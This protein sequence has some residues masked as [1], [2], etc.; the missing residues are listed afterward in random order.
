MPDNKFTIA[1]TGDAIITRR[2]VQNES[3]SE[4]FDDLLDVFSKADVTVTQLETLLHNFEVGPAD[5]Y[6]VH[7]RTPPNVVED[8]TE[9]GCTMFSTATNHVFDYGRHGIQSTI[10]ELDSRN[11]TFAGTGNNLYE[12]RSPA[13][14]ESPAGRVGLVS[15]CSTFPPEADAGPQTEALPGRPGLNPLHVEKVYNL[16]KEYFDN[17]SK[18][19]EIIGLEEIKEEE[20][21]RDLYSEQIEGLNEEFEFG[22][23]MFNIVDDKSK[24]GIDYIVDESDRRN[25][26]EWISEANNNADLVVMAIHAHQGADGYRNTERTPKFLID[27][28]H[29]CIDAGADVIVGTGPHKLRG[30][31]IYD[32][33]PIF[34]S[35]GN[36]ISHLETI[37][38]YSPKLYDD[39]GVRD[40]TKTSKIFDKW[41]YD[42]EGNP[43][44]FLSEESWW[45]SVIP[46]CYFTGETEVEQIKLHPIILQQ[47]QPRSQRGTPMYAPENEADEILE[48]IK[49]LSSSFGT[50]I[51]QDG[52][53]GVINLN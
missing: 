24:A 19:S 29:D 51:E 46:V 5:T 22:E 45:R 48:K 36:F 41:F 37:T 1:A 27:F 11:I 35:L 15:T 43:T 52:D 4:S 39:Y 3:S 40:Y 49:D 38:N 42:E 33:K 23:M 30:I 21:K 12:A 32:N 17:I 53:I 20:S 8:L 10:E 44:S 34:Y 28:A 31:E 13:Y 26:L 9:M 16:P 14:Y 25:N 7:M 6:R 18:V 2:I 50:N 47:D